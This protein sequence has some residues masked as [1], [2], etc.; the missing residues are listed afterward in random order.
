MVDVTY[1]LEG[2]NGDVITF[3]QTQYVL[4]SG[5]VGIGIPPTAV[6]IEESA[7]DGGVWRHTKRQAR[8]VDLPITVFGSNRSDVEAK[9][10]RLGKILQDAQGAPK[11]RA[12]YQNGSSLFLE[13][14]YVGGGETVYDNDQSGLTWATWALILRAP[15]PFWRSGIEESFSIGTGGTGRGLLPQLSKLKVSSSTQ[16]GTVSVI[17]AGDVAAYPVWQITGPITNLVISNGTSSFGFPVVYSGETITV[18]TE[19]G[20]V[21]DADGV[22]QYARLSPAPKLFNLPPGTTTLSVNGVETDLNFNVLLTYSPRYE[23]IH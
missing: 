19:T 9:L 2:A 14:H 21:T 22:N 5:M 10:R 7:G 23:V 16:I 6:R 11:L 1:S 4:R 20:A 17:N 8:D 13:V 18:N 15:N 3:D 12:T